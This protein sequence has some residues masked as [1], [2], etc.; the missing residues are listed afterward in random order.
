MK[1]T[2]L[3][4]AV[5]SFA[6]PALAQE[7]DV[8]GDYASGVAGSPLD[9]PPGVY[10]STAKRLADFFGATKG[11]RTLF[12]DQVKARMAAGPVLLVDVRPKADYDAGHV[13]GAISIPLDVL[14][15]PDNLASLPT[16]GATTI[17][18]I[19]A[20]GHTESMALG[21]LAALGYQP[22]ALRFGSMGW[23]AKTSMKVG[24]SYQANQ[25]I[26]GAGESMQKTLP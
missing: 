14:F 17:V 3:A 25:V 2:I 7:D 1:K 11:A 23:R 8:A 13:P 4:L 24:T 21:G 10:A 6:L 16:D 5:L 15:Q 18:L 19:C 9:V 20:T 22:Y 26:Y 12:S